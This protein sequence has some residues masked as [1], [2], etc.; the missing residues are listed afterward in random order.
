METSTQHVLNCSFSSW[1]PK[2]RRLTIT[3][4]VVPL[5]IEFINYLNAD[6]VVLPQA[7]PQPSTRYTCGDE[8][9]SDL[10]DEWNNASDDE[11]TT[12]PIPTFPKLEEDV[13]QHIRELGGYVFPKLNWS[14]PQD[15]AWISHNGTLQCSTFQDITLLLK[16]SDRVGHDLTKP[17]LS[18]EGC[19]N[20][21]GDFSGYENSITLV[22]FNPFNTLTDTALFEW[23]ELTS[24]QPLAG[25]RVKCPIDDQESRIQIV[26][27]R[28]IEG[29]HGIASNPYLRSKVPLDIAEANSN[30]NASQL[31]E[32]LKLMSKKME[33][34]EI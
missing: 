24:G 20:P 26:I 10:S 12:A 34:D 11:D 28:C 25:H 27:F 7:C 5:P 14:S 9:D 22:D 29:S 18:F 33:N 3:S 32:Y 15:A 8:S 13:N 30:V 31:V 1:Y 19:Q 21:A 4:R 2:F 16:S 6:G 17:H 23:S